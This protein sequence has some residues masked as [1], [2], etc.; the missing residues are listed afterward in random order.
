[1]GTVVDDLRQR[2]DAHRKHAKDERAA[3]KAHILA[4]KELYAKHITSD[5]Q[6]PPGVKGTRVITFD[7]AQSVARPYHTGQT[8]PPYFKTLLKK[9]LFGLVDETR[10][11]SHFFLMDEG[12]TIGQNGTGTDGPDSVV[13]MV[14]YYLSQNHNGEEKLIIYWIDEAK[15]G[16]RWHRGL[17]RR[18]PDI[19]VRVISATSFKKAREWTKDRCEGWIANLQSLGDRGSLDDPNGIWNLD[20]SSFQLARIYDKVYAQKGAQ[21]VPAYVKGSETDRE[22]MTLLALGNSARKMLRPLILYKGKMH[23]ESHFAD[24]NDESFL[25]TNSSGVMNPF[26]LHDYLEKEWS[27]SITTHKNVLFFDGHT[28][29]L[30]CIQFL[31]ACMNISEKEIEVMCLPSGQTAFL[32]PLDKKVFGGVKQKWTKYLQDS[33]LDTSVDEKLSISEDRTNTCI[34]WIKQVISGKLTASVIAR[35][36]HGHLLKA[37]PKKKRMIK[38]SR[39]DTSHGLA[40]VHSGYI[41][42]KADK[43]RTS[44]EAKTKK[45]NDTA[46]NRTPAI[47]KV[48]RKTASVG[49]KAAAKLSESQAAPVV[50]PAVSSNNLG[51]NTAPARK[52]REGNS[53]ARF[54]A[55]QAAVLIVQQLDV[56]PSTAAKQ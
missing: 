23:I 40:L 50:D 34:L 10:S 3:Y 16:N 41:S 13:S 45:R 52:A 33:R 22:N 2:W 51:N 26:V 19:S 11:K 31:A 53:A 5:N 14:D 12:N 43:I 38:D 37:A 54:N 24:T 36:F 17:L 9:A 47:P 18:H 1:M 8:D 49:A 28:S 4:N 55:K 42:L 32:Q 56:S 35:E 29:H 15:F 48:I 25:S 27:T 21:E 7:F 30:N 6:F 20:E 39:L 44:K 46:V